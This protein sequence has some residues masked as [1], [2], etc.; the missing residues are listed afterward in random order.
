MIEP[1]K[2]IDMMNFIDYFYEPI[3]CFYLSEEEIILSLNDGIWK[4]ECGAFNIL[5]KDASEIV[6]ELTNLNAN[7]ELLY[8]LLKNVICTKGVLYR[9]KL[10]DVY[11][12]VGEIEVDAHEEM[13][14][15]FGYELKSK[16]TDIFRRQNIKLL[17]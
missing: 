2:L 15:C 1:E 5:T 8:F 9:M 17:K 14:E 12:L 7:L 10:K 13:W 3:D 4:I 16:I 6:A 11:D